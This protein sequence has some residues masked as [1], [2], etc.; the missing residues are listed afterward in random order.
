MTELNK[1]VTF[2]LPESIVK[3]LDDIKSKRRDPTRSDTVRIL[4][5]QAL[6]AMSFIPASEKK[7][8]GI[9]EQSPMKEAKH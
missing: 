5:L 9:H 6:A 8:L 2:S 7:A 3:L 4:L 1:S